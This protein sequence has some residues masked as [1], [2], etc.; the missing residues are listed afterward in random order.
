MRIRHPAS[1]SAVLVLLG[2]GAHAPPVALSQEVPDVPDVLEALSSDDADQRVLA[3]RWINRLLSGDPPLSVLVE[4]GDGL[5]ELSA[6]HP[7]LIV[8][9]EAVIELADWAEVAAAASPGRAILVLRD[10]FSAIPDAGNKA[11]LV[12]RLP[13]LGVVPGLV[14]LIRDVALTED[15]S[16]GHMAAVALESLARLGGPGRAALRKLHEEN[17]VRPEAARIV[18]SELAKRGFRPIGG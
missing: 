9:G 8:R 2:L 5:A 18:L 1:F 10:A 6:Q 12:G 14:P 4:L 16:E 7:S 15:L 11:Y 13:R 17:S 3:K